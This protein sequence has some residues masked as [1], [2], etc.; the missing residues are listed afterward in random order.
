MQIIERKVNEHTLYTLKAEEGMFI[1]DGKN[2]AKTV[3]LGLGASTCAFRDATV[4]E[5]ENAKGGETQSDAV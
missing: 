1:T 3:H 2:Y 4:E 5:Y